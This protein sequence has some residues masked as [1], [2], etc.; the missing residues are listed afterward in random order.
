L[1]H[2]GKADRKKGKTPSTGG[3]GNNPG[4][5]WTRGVKVVARRLRT[6]FTETKKRVEH[7]TSENQATKR[8]KGKKR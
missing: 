8:E 2:V 5:S 6:T 4:K 1:H 3:M 7:E